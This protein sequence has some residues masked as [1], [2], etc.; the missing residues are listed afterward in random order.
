MK[1]KKKLKVNRAS[2]ND[3]FKR[4]YAYHSVFFF[5][6]ARSSR[7]EGEK[8]SFTSQRIRYEVIDRVL[9]RIRRSAYS[10]RFP[11]GSV[12]IFLAVHSD[13]KNYLVLVT[14]HDYSWSRIHAIQMDKIRFPLENALFDPFKFYVVQYHT[15]VRYQI[16]HRTFLDSPSL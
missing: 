12:V 9:S 3:E 14:K 1:K 15:F 16:S 11:R 6:L 4:S 8:S 5:F 13:V 7:K 10:D 2:L